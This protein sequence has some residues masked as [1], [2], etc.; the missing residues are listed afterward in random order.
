M[1]TT[2]GDPGK[3][4]RQCD[5]W[6]RTTWRSN[7]TSLF[8]DFT[9]WKSQPW[10]VYAVYLSSFV[11]FALFYDFALLYTTYLCFKDVSDIDTKTAL[12]YMAGLLFFSKMV[13]PF[14]HF[15]RNPLDIIY[16]PGYILFG[17]FHSFVKL[18]ALLTVWRISW[19]TR[20]V[21]GGSYQYATGLLAQT[22]PI[23]QN[24]KTVPTPVPATCV[25]R[26]PKP[27]S[28]IFSTRYPLAPLITSRP[29]PYFQRL[30]FPPSEAVTQ[31]Q[32]HA[33]KRKLVYKQ[34]T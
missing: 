27:V 2:L 29:T 23:D 11:N 1:E 26:L 14:P 17:Y 34:F 9:V 21:D 33:R 7:S 10:C 22:Y 24:G 28:P 19:G 32:A 5:R 6:V 13:K 15:W 30:K 12:K 25:E 16:I 31:A 4:L 18:K 8:S 3:F 20:D